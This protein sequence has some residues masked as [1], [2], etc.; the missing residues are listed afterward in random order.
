MDD[1]V[2]VFTSELEA[3][4]TESTVL[5]TRTVR[6]RQCLPRYKLKLIRKKNAEWLKAKDAV[7]KIAYYKLRNA[8][9]TSLAA[10]R[11]EKEKQLINGHNKS[12]FYRFINERIGKRSSLQSLTISNNTGIK[13]GKEVAEIFS[14]EFSSKFS[15]DANVPIEF[16]DGSE[17]GLMF[18]CTCDDVLRLLSSFPIRRQA[19][20]DIHTTP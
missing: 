13:K 10:W 5:K 11:A 3:A 9:R 16:S 2:S 4:I 19:L 1:F 15:Q 17:E 6:K 8:F 12:R 7:D 20:M 14:N 18:N